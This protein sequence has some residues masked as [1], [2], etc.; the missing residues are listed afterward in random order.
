MEPSKHNASEY[1]RYDYFRE[2]M[3]DYDKLA[4]RYRDDIRKDLVESPDSTERTKRV[5]RDLRGIRNTLHDFKLSWPKNSLGRIIVKHSSFDIMTGMLNPD[6]PIPAKNLI[7]F[8]D[9]LENHLLSWKYS[10]NY[11]PSNMGSDHREIEFYV[12]LTKKISPDK[13][14]SDI[15]EILSYGVPITQ[16]T[17]HFHR[18]PGDI[19]F[20][21]TEYEF[22]NTTINIYNILD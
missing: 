2:E 9:M 12:N 22:C 14:L 5:N 7:A 20:H 21:E 19:E 3:K 6:Q 17:L 10:E 11:H 4:K 15:E 8:I 16:W 1:Q 13:I 18:G